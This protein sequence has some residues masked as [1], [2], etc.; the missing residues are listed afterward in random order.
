MLA[1]LYTAAGQLYSSKH[2]CK[3]I[4]VDIDD[5]MLYFTHKD[6]EVERIT[7]NIKDRLPTRC[8]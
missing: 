5:A 4:N 2:A 8:P 7:R 1:F 3:A 6:T